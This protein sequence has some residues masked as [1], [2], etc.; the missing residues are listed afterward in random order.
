MNCSSWERLHHVCKVNFWKLGKGV[1]RRWLSW[2]MG[3]VGQANQLH[4]REHGAGRREEGDTKNCPWSHQPVHDG[5]HPFHAM[6]ALSNPTIGKL[7]LAQ[8]L[9]LG[10]PGP[11]SHLWTN[12]EPAG[13]KGLILQDLRWNP[14]LSASP[15]H[16]HQCL[17]RQP[18]WSPVDQGAMGLCTNLHST[19]KTPVR[20]IYSSVILL[21][22]DL[23]DVDIL[24]CS[25]WF[26]GK[27]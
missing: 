27:F 7:I 19:Q 10:L 1:S 8:F 17:L 25:H 18:G 20:I 9:V 14:S 26:P 21:S 11:P 4:S 23:L 12:P 15:Y 13:L 5:S 2:G 6:E 22:W 16:T 3:N 24:V